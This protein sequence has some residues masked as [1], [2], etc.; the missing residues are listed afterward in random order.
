MAKVLL[1]QQQLCRCALM[2][3]LHDGL[4]RT[5]AIARFS[6]PQITP[7]RAPSSPLLPARSSYQPG[8]RCVR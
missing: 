6:L 8:R 2:A 5:A 1:Q 3:A 7:R 4:D